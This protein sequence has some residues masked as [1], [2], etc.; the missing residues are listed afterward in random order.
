MKNFD[1]FLDLK[2]LLKGSLDTPATNQVA[3]HSNLKCV[4]DNCASKWLRL[5]VCMCVFFVGACDVS[6][7]CELAM[8]VAFL[9]GELAM[10]VASVVFCEPRVGM[11]R[12]MAIIVEGVSCKGGQVGP[13][14]DAK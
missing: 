6:R 2:V 3:V 11:E 10:F 8:L 1:K 5:N 14:W 4:C 7:L 9:L 12:V 13:S